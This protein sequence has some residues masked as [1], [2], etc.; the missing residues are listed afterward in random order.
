MHSVRLRPAAVAAGRLLAQLETLD[1][2]ACR[3]GPKGIAALCRS[4]HVA[5]V[6]NLSLPQNPFGRA[7]AK[8]LAAAL[9]PGLLPNVKLDSCGLDDAAFKLLGRSRSRGKVVLQRGSEAAPRE[10]HKQQHQQNRAGIRARQVI[11]DNRNHQRQRDQIGSATRMSAR[12]LL[13]DFRT[14]RQTLFNCPH[15]LVFCGVITR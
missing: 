3:I 2:T 7:G 12:H 1:L 14:Q 4:P 10:K 9:P 13:H 5:G 11:E 8:V 15:R 6:R